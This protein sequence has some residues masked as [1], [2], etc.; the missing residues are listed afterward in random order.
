ME[1]HFLFDCIGINE[2]HLND[3]LF[4][5]GISKGKIKG[6][7]ILKLSNF[8]V[9]TCDEVVIN[10]DG[11]KIGTGSFE[12]SVVKEGI[13]IIVP[14]ITKLRKNMIPKMSIK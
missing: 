10:L 13:D 5:R 3:L 6:V 11:E 8:K 7:T 12:F 1:R 9:E 14:S 4:L 2:C